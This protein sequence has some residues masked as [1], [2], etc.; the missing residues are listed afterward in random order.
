MPSVWE[1]VQVSSLVINNGRGFEGVVVDVRCVCATGFQSQRVT[2]PNKMPSNLGN[3]A[4]MISFEN[5]L[6]AI[7]YPSHLVPESPA[8][9]WT[10][11]LPDATSS[12]VPGL[13]IRRQLEIMLKRAGLGQTFHLFYPLP[14]S[15]CLSLSTIPLSRVPHRIS[16]ARTTRWQA[17]RRA[18]CFQLLV[19][20]PARGVLEVV[21]LH[22]PI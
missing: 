7:C 10:H 22:E 11:S 19:T 16:P 6:L 12:S 21:L 13:N 2:K 15:P 5:Q 14:F 8:C 9:P 1:K 20:T 17:I 18:T 4:T 3:Y